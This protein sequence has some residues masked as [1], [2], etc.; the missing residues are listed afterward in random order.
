MEW[1]DFADLTPY[2]RNA[3]RHPDGQVYA[4]ARVGLSVSEVVAI[5]EDRPWRRM[6]EIQAVDDLLPWNIGASN[7]IP[8][9]A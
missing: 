9:A 2:D 3:K 6:G 1:P 4:I 7:A 5:L 8:R